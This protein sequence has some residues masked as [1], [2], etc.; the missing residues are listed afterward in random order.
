M[1]LYVFAHLALRATSHH[2]VRN[3]VSHL[4][5][6]HISLYNRTLRTYIYLG[7][8]R[9][10]YAHG[11]NLSAES[12]LPSVAAVC[13]CKSRILCAGITINRICLRDIRDIIRAA[14][15]LYHTSQQHTRHVMWR[16]KKKKR[17]DVLEWKTKPYLACLLT[18]YRTYL[19]TRLW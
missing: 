2:N 5:R 1:L 15:V 10:G 3:S 17:N 11:L 16:R 7:C 6:A 8:G 18:L 19:R 9:W 12:A 14:Y 13:H 4:I